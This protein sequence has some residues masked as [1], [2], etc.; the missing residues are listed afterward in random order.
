M[1][2]K[3]YPSKT[4]LKPGQTFTHERYGPVVVQTVKR[5]RNNRGI[6]SYDCVKVTYGT[7]QTIIL[8]MFSTY[9]LDLS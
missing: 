6:Q 2:R 5:A 9:G 4:G 1:S 8:P 3:T 7:G